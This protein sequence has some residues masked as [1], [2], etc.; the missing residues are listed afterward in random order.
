MSRI[1]EAQLNL[2]RHSEP[3]NAETGPGLRLTWGTLESA[4]VQ[5]ILNAPIGSF[6][7]RNGALT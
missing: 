2:V 5:P 7:V 3:R 1:N 4:T 6:T